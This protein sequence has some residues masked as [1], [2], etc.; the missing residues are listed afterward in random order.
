MLDASP[1]P[2]RMFNLEGTFLGFLGDNPRKPRSIILE[3]DQ[4]PMAIR[5]PKE[6]RS[7]PHECLKP[8]DR[9]HCVG[10][11]EV[12][13]KARVIKLQ[14]YQIFSVA[15]APETAAEPAP[16][17]PPVVADGIP[18][19]PSLEPPLPAPPAP[20]AKPQWGTIKL[21][22][23]SGCQKRGGRQIAAALEQALQDHHLQDQVTVQYTGCQKRCSKAPSLT[24]MPGKHRYDRLHPRNISALIEEHFCL[25]ESRSTPSHGDAE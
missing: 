2:S 25:P 9:I 18:I 24:I 15:P 20:T 13:F 17:M 22:H 4:E 21:C 5:L 23:K 8:G 14:A 3:V 19:E 10:R 12:D 16:P 1:L 7:R 11:S 6:L